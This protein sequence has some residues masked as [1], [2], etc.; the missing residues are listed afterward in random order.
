MKVSTFIRVA[1]LG[2]VVLPI[3]AWLLPATG[4]AAIGLIFTVGIL[5]YGIGYVL[6]AMA[7]LTWLQRPRTEREV[8]R[9]TLI[10]PALAAPL[11]ATSV[12]L[13]SFLLGTGGRDGLTEFFGMTGIAL[14]VGYA[15]AGLVLLI[16]H[17]VAFSSGGNRA[18][19]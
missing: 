10:A 2:P 3:L 4:V 11:L 14:V 8:I 9:A 6:F 19:V 5:Y 18:A 13:T 15:Y 16:G 17:F 12:V 1:L 7:V